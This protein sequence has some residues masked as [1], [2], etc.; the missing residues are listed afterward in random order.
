MR[1][2][3]DLEGAHTVMGRTLDQI[4]LGPR[5]C[6]IESDEKGPFLWVG[7]CRSVGQAR[8]M[9]GWRPEALMAVVGSVLPAEPMSE[10]GR[11]PGEHELDLMEKITHLFEVHSDW[12]SQVQVGLCLNEASSTQRVVTG[13]ILGVPRLEDGPEEATLDYGDIVLTRFHVKPNATPRLIM[14]LVTR[15]VVE[16]PSMGDIRLEA[17]LSAYGNKPPLSHYRRESRQP[18]SY[19][20]SS[21]PFYY[22]E[23]NVPQRDQPDRRA[24]AKKDLPLYP[25]WYSGVH[26][27]LGIGDKPEDC[28]NPRGIALVL[29][30]PRARL[31]EVLLSG[32]TINAKVRTGEAKAKG[33]LVKMFASLGERH[34]ADVQLSAEHHLAENTF[35]F[36]PT[37]VSVHLVTDGDSERLDGRDID[38]RWGTVPPGVIVER[39]QETL[40]ELMERGEGDTVD[41]KESL[42]ASVVQDKLPKVVSSFAN[43]RGGVVFLGVD[44]EGE[45]V[46]S[47]DR[48]ARDTISQVLTA[49]LEPLPSVEFR[50]LQ[51]RGFDLVAVLVA[52]G[53]DKP[54]LFKGRGVFVRYNG[55]SRQATRNE[56]LGLTSKKAGGPAQF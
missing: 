21:W 46:N 33:L 9:Q 5:G 23:I 26:Y 15:N 52:E 11:N 56:L 41:Y 54:Y 27:F 49:H 25:N 51:H 37:V 43:T 34:H 16:H 2:K 12:Y 3:I 45:P 19:V 40:V 8:Q 18:W 50:A 32:R 30:D 17:S 22:F 31:D 44:D 7:G 13:S 48:K 10:N 24:L 38:L 28:Q 1:W 4:G 47:I 20:S 53:A 6:G 39:S 29:P 35:D 55:T 36:A 42:S 14:D